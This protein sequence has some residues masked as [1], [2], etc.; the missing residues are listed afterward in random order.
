MD[1]D[2]SVE[3]IMNLGIIAS[4]ITAS[5]VPTWV[6]TGEVSSPLANIYVQI[7]I[8]DWP[9]RVAEAK[10]YIDNNYPASN[11]AENYTIS[12]EVER[13]IYLE[14]MVKYL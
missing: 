12:V 13:D 1:I 10:Q 2:R 8:S 7:S 9:N 4:Q 11:Y 6:F 3:I 14:F 5:K